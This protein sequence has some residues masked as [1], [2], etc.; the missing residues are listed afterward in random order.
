MRMRLGGPPLAP[1]KRSHRR[2]RL[3][4]EPAR[5]WAAASDGSSTRSRAPRARAG[6][7]LPPAAARPARRT[8]EFHCALS[9]GTGIHPLHATTTVSRVAGG[10]AV[11]TSRTKNKCTS[12]IDRPETRRIYTTVRRTWRFGVT[13]SQG[14]GSGS[15][16][17]RPPSPERRPRDPGRSQP[18]RGC[19]RRRPH[20]RGANS[21]R[22]HIAS[23]RARCDGADAKR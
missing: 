11:S 3:R 19:Q 22:G 10:C 8:C 9:R 21:S 15:R 18:S 6:T 12:R 5:S 14:R 17:K 13:I 16:R 1:S 2:D 20:Q 4:D 7:P 23:A